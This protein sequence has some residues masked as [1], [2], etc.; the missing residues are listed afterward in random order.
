MESYLQGLNREQ[1][2]AVKHGAGPCMVL[3]GPGTGKT[4]VITSRVINLIKSR[5]VLPENIL[6]VTFSRAAA[7]EMKE[8]YD[9]LSGN[10]MDG[11]VS[12]G[13]FHS[14]FYKLLRQYK[15]YKLEDLIDE[16]HKFN[17]I[18]NF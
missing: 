7:N 8:R 11:K 10:Q 2:T 6:V 5:R 4:T 16:N 17:I 13:T 18:R 3:A 14:V 12:F 9:R 1:L 15:G